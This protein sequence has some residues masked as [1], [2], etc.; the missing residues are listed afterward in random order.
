M[1][2]IILCIYCQPTVKPHFSARTALLKTPGTDNLHFFKEHH[3]QVH[4]TSNFLV[5]LWN[6]LGTKILI[7]H[8]LEVTERYQRLLA[9]QSDLTN[10]PHLWRRVLICNNYLFGTNSST[11][12]HAAI[13]YS[14]S[15]HGLLF[16]WLLLSFNLSS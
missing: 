11:A 2:I 16:P 4:F 1:N 10:V 12:I 7:K 14:T 8:L 9:F 5:A 15:G 6:Q 13:P 3:S